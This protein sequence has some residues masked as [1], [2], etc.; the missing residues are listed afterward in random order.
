LSLL[1]VPPIDYAVMLFR[2]TCQ[3]DPAKQTGGVWI[4]GL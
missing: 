3:S 2:C 1:A 4:V